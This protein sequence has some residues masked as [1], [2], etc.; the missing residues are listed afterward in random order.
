MEEW[1]TGEFAAFEENGW[2]VEELTDG[3]LVISLPTP[4]IQKNQ[5]VHP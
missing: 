5:R 1:E 3:A 2:G 4:Q